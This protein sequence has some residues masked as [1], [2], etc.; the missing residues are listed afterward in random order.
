M[1]KKRKKKQKNNYFLIYIVAII[2]LGYMMLEET[3]MFIGIVTSKPVLV[4]ISLVISYFLLKFAIKR[5]L[6]KM[7]QNRYLRSN[8]GKVDKMT[9]PE[10]EEYLAAHFDNLGYKVEHIG[11]TGDYGADLILYRD[12]VSIVVQA[13]RY[14]DKVGVKAVQEVISAK[15]YY[16]C[17][18][19]MVVTNSYFTPNA[20]QMATQCNVELWDRE[21]IRKEFPNV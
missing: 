19:A 20:I 9:G 1:K 2:L 3:D 14:Q 17:D 4:V 16:E 10:F 15:E 8:L 18:S 12:G 6:K 11:Q 21:D 7:K 13:K 5:L